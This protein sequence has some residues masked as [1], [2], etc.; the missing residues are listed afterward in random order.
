[1]VCLFVDG[2]R[3][4]LSGCWP[5]FQEQLVT[6]APALSGDEI[7]KEFGI[8]MATPNHVL[9]TGQLSIDWPRLKEIIVRGEA[10]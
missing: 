8:R 4:S 10:A 5:L 1:M 9:R 2:R 7:D 3:K 6:A